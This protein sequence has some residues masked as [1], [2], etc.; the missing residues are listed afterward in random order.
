MKYCW[1]TINVSD[2]DKS[3]EFYR[4]IIG[5]ELNRRFK[6][7][8][9]MEIAFLG[10]GETQIELIF[11]KNITTTGFGLDISLGFVVESV[12]QFMEELKTKKI[13]I[14]SGPFQPNPYIRFFFIVDPDGLKI[15]F[16]ENIPQN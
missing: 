6:P 12:S 2:M 11:N 16:V 9:E 1:T 10:D 7:N 14:H 15:Q 4:D 5:L 8:E 3:L 13:E